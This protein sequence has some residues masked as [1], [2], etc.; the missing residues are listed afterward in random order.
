M[1]GASGAQQPPKQT[2]KVLAAAAAAAVADEERRQPQGACA[3]DRGA[4]SVAGQAIPYLRS[5]Q[6]QHTLAT[7]HR[8]PDQYT[9]RSPGTHIHRI[10]L[11]LE[12]CLP[13][14]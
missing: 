5:S 2:G 3:G 7:L 13:R 1:Y 8:R 11:S 9:L 4:Y 12:L 14:L 6:V 10:N